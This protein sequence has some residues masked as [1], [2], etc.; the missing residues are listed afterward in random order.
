MKKKVFF[1]GG[2][3]NHGAEAAPLVLRA[4]GFPEA[5]VPGSLD[6]RRSLHSRNDTLATA[7]SWLT[8][9]TASG[10]AVTYNMRAINR[11]RALFLETAFTTV[12]VEDGVW[13]LP[14]VKGTWFTPAGKR[15]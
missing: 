1:C 13:F 6:P 4:H 10:A 15:F 7:P 11:S 5:C 14:A 3:P 8:R 12:S 2:D 9:K